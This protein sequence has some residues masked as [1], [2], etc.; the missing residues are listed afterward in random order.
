MKPKLPIPEPLRGSDP[1]SFAHST[2]V[3]RLP[4]I[5]RRTLD[6]NDFSPEIVTRLKSLEAELPDGPIRTLTDDVAP[7]SHLWHAYLRPYLGQDWL[8]IPW[9]L[10]EAY[11]YR[12]ILEATGYFLSGP[13]YL[14]D[15]FAHQKRQG[16]KTSRGLIQSLCANRNNGGKQAD[17]SW[18]SLSRLIL[19]D[20]WGNR[21]D[22]SL[23]PAAEGETE[24]AVDHHQPETYL[25][26]DNR[27]QLQTW[28]DRQTLPLS[29]L[30]II[31]DNAGFEL[32][33]D[34]A[35]VDCLLH[36]GWVTTIQ[37][38]LK[39]HPTFV[40]DAL[41]KNV[42]QTITFL[43]DETD[44]AVQALGNRLLRYLEAGRLVLRQD[45]FWTAPLSF[46]EMPS[47]LRDDLAAAHLIISKGD[48]NY[49]RALGD[50]HWPYHTP[51]DDIA[52]YFPAPFL[53]LRTLKSEIVAGL[54]PQQPAHLTAQD[55]DWLTNG[56][57]GV[58]QLA[59]N[60][61]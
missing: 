18:P 15:P 56:H 17:L 1:D 58:I 6:E 25:L 19:N 57:W 20:L 29:R 26:V 48:A 31:I 24:V 53:A 39:A 9:F 11:F 49:R 14:L 33:C 42:Q 43:Q 32:V 45:F 3:I 5:V 60:N 10:A 38:H 37:L 27:P 41:I 51:F 7:D 36:E 46:W 34:L 50:C 21:A 59:I 22:L 44:G 61:A 30:D 28:F 47:A 13:T 54:S 2:V 8:Q 52:G 4:E 16:L 23:W 55:P 40:S 35:V 12:R